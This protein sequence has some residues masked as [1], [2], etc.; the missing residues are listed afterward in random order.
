MGATERQRQR[1]EAKKRIEREKEREIGCFYFLQQSI[2][3]G[4]FSEADVTLT[5]Y[6]S[7]IPSVD[8]QNTWE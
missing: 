1:E 2:R 7:E 8:K 3:T 6:T 5:L 4:L